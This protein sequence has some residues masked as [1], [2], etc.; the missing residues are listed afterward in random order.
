MRILLYLILFTLFSSSA[1]ADIICKN[2]NRTKYISKAKISS[3]ITTLGQGIKIWSEGKLI[4]IPDLRPECLPIPL[5][6]NNPGAL[7]TPSKG[8]WQGQINKDKYGHA[9]FDSM[10]NGTKAWIT[11]I[12]K[13]FDANKPITAMKIMSVYAPEDDCVGSIGTPP[14][15]CKYGLNPTKQYASRVA[16]AINKGPLDPIDINKISCIEKENLYYKLFIQIATFEIG[17]GFCGRMNT[18][19]P[20]MCDVSTSMFKD[21]YLKVMQESSN[22][23]GNS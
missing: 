6:Y 3:P 2:P 4:D 16:S 14:D 17:G 7:K 1:Y 11:W 13:K 18:Q 8:P 21:A 23:C 9:V 20:Q 10:G 12:N 19:S 5:R 15:N 22:K